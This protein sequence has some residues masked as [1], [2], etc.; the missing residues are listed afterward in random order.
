MMELKQPIK[1]ISKQIRL[2]ED[3]ITE[4]DIY[5]LCNWLS[6][7]P[8]PRLTKGKLTIEFENQWAEIIGT[9][10]SVM[11]N[12]GSSA[13]LLSL[14]SL[15]ITNRLRNKKVCV[16]AL[17]W[18]TDLAPVMQ[19]GL[20]PLIVD[21]N[22]QDL[23]VDLLDLERVFQ[24]ENPDV[25]ILVSVLGLVPDMQRITTLCN[26]YNVALIEDVCE[27]TGSRFKDKKLGSFGLLSCHS[28]YYGHAFS[29]IEGGMVC[30]ND[31]NIYHTLLMC[32]SHGWSRD[33]PEAKRKELQNE[34]SINDF[35]NLYA[36]YLP[37]FNLRSTDLNAFIGLRQIKRFNEV[38]AKRFENYKLYHD[39]LYGLGWNAPE[40]AITNNIVC[41]LGYPIIHKKRDEIV[42]E[43][44]QSKIEVRPLI[45]G[46]LGA[47]PFYTDRYPK[48]QLPNVLEVDK[49]GM[50]L[51]NHCGMSKKDIRFICEIINEITK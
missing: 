2:A 40:Y 18:S 22:L 42:K 19:L 8:T 6:E 21:C 49:F 38:V 13:I 26:E 3:T 9:K 5:A 11:V 28:L 1:H 41:N 46:S 44:T 7:T 35:D 37:S 25:L 16:P 10:Y 48:L 43:L 30:T 17:S 33:L 23:S 36:F 47:Q 31:E 32:R 39:C 34:Y 50:Y 20:T 29:T 14:Y 24:R 15:L 12:S 51:P 27:S 45:A 4:T